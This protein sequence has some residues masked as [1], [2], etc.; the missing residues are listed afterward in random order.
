MARK[1]STFND[2]YFPNNISSLNEK[3][4]SSSSLA[5]AASSST[6]MGMIPSSIV[7]STIPL[8]TTATASISAPT[9][10]TTSPLHSIA[11]SM[12]AAAKAAEAISISRPPPSF[13]YNFNNYPRNY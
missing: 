10:T 7:T 4:S 1:E 5:A 13:G 8:T 3:L 12:L 6:S 9:T 2:F 11:D